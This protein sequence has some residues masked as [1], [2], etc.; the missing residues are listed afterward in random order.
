MIEVFFQG[1]FHT[2]VNFLY[3]PIIF[4]RMLWIL[5]PAILSILLMEIYF[6]RYPR[7]NIEYHKSMEN[8]IFLLFISFDLLRY[9]VMDTTYN[10][11]KIYLSIAFIAFSIIIALLDF[12]HKLPVALL[13]RL[14]SKFIIAFVSYLVVVLIYS[15]M[16]DAISA[17]GLVYILISIFIF[18]LLI[19]LVRRILIV[20]EPKSYEEIDSFLEVIEK[21]LKKAIE[22]SKDNISEDEHKTKK[23]KKKISHPK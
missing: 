2:L 7:L 3:A 4:P 19:V 16:L 11:L 17:I 1:L 14:S 6:W 5:I 22:E 18:F 12:Y 8:T 15:D 9:L 10:P 20:F 23:T 13:S 21:D